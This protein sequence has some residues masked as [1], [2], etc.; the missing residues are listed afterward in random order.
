MFSHPVLFLFGFLCGCGVILEE[1]FAG[2]PLSGDL[3]AEMK[4]LSPSSDLAN[5]CA[6]GQACDCE[7]CRS[8]KENL[9][10]D[11]EWS[12]EDAY[13]FYGS[14]LLGTT[15]ATFRT[16]ASA[17]NTAPHASSSTGSVGTAA[18]AGGVR[19]NRPYGAIRLECEGA[20]REIYDAPPTPDSQ[21]SIHVRAADNWS[22]LANAWRD[23]A[24][25][26]RLG[27]Y[28]GGGVGGGGFRLTET[29][30]NGAVAY[31]QPSLFAWQAGGGATWQYNSLVTLDASYRFLAFGTATSTLIQPNGMPAGLVSSTMTANEILLMIR[32]NEPWRLAEHVW[33]AR[34]WLPE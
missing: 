12:D 8:S 17:P 19:F 23:V 15:I 11:S 22:V 30:A 20:L 21:Q 2:T 5:E 32:V 24:L 7:S 14:K 13:R 6:D 16:T 28:A 27:M 31:W 29:A 34:L 1:A 33:N 18:Y 4:E 9:L 25:T 10:D 3:T 26:E